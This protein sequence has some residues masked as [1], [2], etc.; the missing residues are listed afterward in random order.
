MKHHIL[1][2]PAAERDVD[3]QAEYL[4]LQAGVEMGLRFYQASEE[5]FLLLA[6]RPGIG[7]TM[8]FRNRSLTGIRMF[9]L[10]GF[11]RHLVFYL[12]L[13]DGVEI[14]RLLHG[15]RDIG[16]LFPDC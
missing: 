14:V 8:A 13:Q 3:E 6:K 7:R 16:S 4:A 1:V 15:S 2:R 5:T 12:P 9:P 11:P 10:K